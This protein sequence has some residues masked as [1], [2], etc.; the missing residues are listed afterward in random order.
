[1]TL[2]LPEVDSKRCDGCGDCVKMCPQG[3]IKLVGGKATI[4]D[5][6]K[7]GYCAECEDFCPA[8]AIRCPFEI[9]L[10]DTL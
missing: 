6:E 4:V 9:V 3:I 8:G 1:M 10:G 7:C 2:I 5:V